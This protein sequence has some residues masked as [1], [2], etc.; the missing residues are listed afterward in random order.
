MTSAATIVTPTLAGPAFTAPDMCRLLSTSPTTLWRRV[1]LGEVP[2][3]LRVG[4]IKVWPADQLKSDLRDATPHI[5]TLAA[6]LAEPEVDD[7]IKKSIRRSTP[8]AALLAEVLAAVPDISPAQKEAPAGG[9]RR[10]RG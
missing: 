5:D 8:R 7:L 3:P 2:A 9:I 10:G 4:H 1:R 6:L